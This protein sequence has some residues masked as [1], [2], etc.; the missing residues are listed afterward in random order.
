M[1]VWVDDV[2]AVHRRCLEQLFGGRLAADR[3]AM[4]LPRDAGPPPDGHV[5]RIGKG[6]S[7]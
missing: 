1:S 5:V 4:G 6:T 3:P 2:D 7:S